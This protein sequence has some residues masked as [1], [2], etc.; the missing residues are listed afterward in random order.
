MFDTL[1]AKLSPVWY[2]PDSEEGKDNPIRFQ[3]KPLTPPELDSALFNS[4]RNERGEVKEFHP[5][6]VQFAMNVGIVDWENVGEDF[7]PA[8]INSIRWAWRQELV[9][10]IVAMGVLAGKEVKNS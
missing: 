5:N 3:L 9:T 10:N 2:T 1:V 4:T 6:G 8:K 7:S